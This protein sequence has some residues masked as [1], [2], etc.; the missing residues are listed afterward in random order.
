[1]IA[2]ASRTGNVRHIVRRLRLPAVEIDEHTALRQPFLL[3]TYTDKLGE[4]PEAVSRFMARN[5]AYCRGVAVSGNRNFGPH[6]FGRAGDIIAGQW[7]IPLIRKME[8]RGFPGDY[9]AI[10]RFHEAHIGSH[11]GSDEAHIGS[12]IEGSE[13]EL[14]SSIGSYEAHIGRE[15]R[16]EIVFAA[17]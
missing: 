11:I 5:G 9:E 8:L 16:H 2:F 14:E 1:V 3:I 15:L 13:A 7:R 17:Q 12:H 4:V 6:N 10:R